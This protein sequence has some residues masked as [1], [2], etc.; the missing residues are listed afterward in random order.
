[1]ATVTGGVRNSPAGAVVC[2]GVPLSELM[3]PESML[4][5]AIWA[6]ALAGRTLTSMRAV[7][8][9]DAPGTTWRD[10]MSNERP[11]R[12]CEL[13]CGVEVR[14]AGVGLLDQRRRRLEA[15]AVLL[16]E[17]A[18]PGDETG[19]AAVVAVDVLQHAA[20]P[21]READAHDGADVGVGHGLDHALVEALDALHRL[22][23][24]HPLLQVAQVD[25]GRVL[26]RRERVPQARP[27]PHPLA[28]GV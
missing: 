1:M 11:S 20:R 19:Q 27:Q 8:T 25:R 28:V 2:A 16:R 23:E 9:P 7:S 14:L 5:A 12:C 18:R 22:D 10:G 13:L 21:A 17:L 15:L 26:D 3:M 24:E 4:S 6:C